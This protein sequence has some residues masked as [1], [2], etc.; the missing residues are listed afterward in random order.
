MPISDS[1][2]LDLRSLRCFAYAAERGSLT[3]AATSMGI[4]Q[5]ALSR[6]ISQLEAILGGRLFYRTGRG[7]ELTELGQTLLPRTEIMLR[8]A[9]E[10]LDAAKAIQH[11]PTGV[12]NVALIPSMSKPLVG[13]LL[14]CLQKEF[15]EIHIRAFEAYSGEVETML[16]EGRVDIGIFNRYR[17]LKRETQDAIFSSTMC[18]VGK[19]GSKVSDIKSARFSTVGALPLALP[20][21]PNSMRSFFD[22]IANKQRLQLNVVL[23][24]ST[25]AIIK[26]AVLNCNLYS[27]LPPHAVKDELATGLLVAIPV[28][29]PVVRQVTFVDATPRHPMTGASREVLRL[30]QMLVQQLDKDETTS[31]RFLPATASQRP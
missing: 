29:H 19:A 11:R 2:M 10:L 23:E 20:T 7:V 21:R 26:D 9:R 30:L 5:S 14:N 16:A 8:E 1:S 6:H 3:S 13:L 12:V 25:S 24:A 28:T 27:V 17:P 18:L 22:E 15:P 31:A 4:A